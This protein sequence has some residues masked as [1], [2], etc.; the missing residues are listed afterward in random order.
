MAYTNCLDRGAGML[1]LTLKTE[2][3]KCTQCLPE[4]ESDRCI[5]GAAGEMLAYALCGC[6]CYGDAAAAIQLILAL[7]DLGQMRC[8]GTGYP[9]GLAAATA[10]LLG[11]ARRIEQIWDQHDQELGLA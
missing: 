1:K 2:H 10:D 7:A 9:E 8:E 6:G 4:L 5:A 11:A 3:A